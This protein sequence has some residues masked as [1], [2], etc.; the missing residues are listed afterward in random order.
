MLPKCFRLFGGGELLINPLI[1]IL[2]LALL[3]EVLLPG[4][5]LLGNNILVNV[6]IS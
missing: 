5:Q 4:P 2:G 3:F 6:W 1:V